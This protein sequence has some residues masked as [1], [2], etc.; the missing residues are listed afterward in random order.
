VWLLQAA[1]RGPL[2]LLGLYLLS[3]ASACCCVAHLI[4]VCPVTQSLPCYMP[5]RISLQV[6]WTLLTNWF[7]LQAVWR[8]NLLGRLLS[9]SPNAWLQPLRVHCGSS[10]ELLLRLY[11][12]LQFALYQCAGVGD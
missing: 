6:V 8:T 5:S 3:G 9:L 12:V 2:D 11:L 10:K 1:T 4:V 7:T